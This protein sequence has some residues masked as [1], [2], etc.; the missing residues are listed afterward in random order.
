[1][2][3]GGIE[4]EADSA[5][6]S[7]W[8]AWPWL[9]RRGGSAERRVARNW[10]PSSTQGEGGAIMPLT[11]D[12]RMQRAELYFRRLAEEK[13]GTADEKTYEHLRLM[14][15]TIQEQIRLL[16]IWKE[17]MEDLRHKVSVP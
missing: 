5:G 14:A 16:D 1:V 3:G 8:A 2:R 9:P 13:A 10:Q 12:E 4:E 11:G 17:Q 15:E 7:G 6:A